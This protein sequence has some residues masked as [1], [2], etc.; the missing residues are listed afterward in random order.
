MDSQENVPPQV[1]ALWRLERRI[2]ISAKRRG[3]TDD[4][5]DDLM[6]EL[7][8]KLL[9]RD[10]TPYL[11]DQFLLT[12]ADHLLIDLLRGEQRRYVCLRALAA[13]YRQAEMPEEGGGGPCCYQSS[14]ERS[15]QE[16]GQRIE[17]QELCDLLRS[18][19]E[20]LSE[21]DRE[22]IR[23]RYFEE[24]RDRD[25]AKRFGRR[26]GTIRARLKRA[27]DRLRHLC[28][29][30]HPDVAAAFRPGRAKVG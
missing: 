9:G 6:Q 3:A 27:R 22:L 20:L 12:M 10:V 21:Q 15:G 17:H 5:S 14:E 7:A 18:A 13:S 11:S 30:H 8:K 24:L 29:L 4:L 23:A 28:C 1:I 19:L 25:L 2:R 16:P 26:E